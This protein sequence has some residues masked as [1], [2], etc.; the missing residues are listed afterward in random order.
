MLASRLRL[1][2]EG[3]VVLLDPAQ[4]EACHENT[5]R[6]WR[7]RSAD[8]GELP[9]RPGHPGA[10]PAGALPAQGGAWRRPGGDL[11]DPLEAG[12]ADVLPILAGYLFRERRS[13]H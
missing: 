7:Y 2:V 9:C 6:A 11:P 8:P 10:A 1:P 5:G 12:P 4:P 13:S 3:G